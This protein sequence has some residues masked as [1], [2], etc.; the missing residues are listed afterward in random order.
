MIVDTLMTSLLMADCS[1]KATYC[2][3]WIICYPNISRLLCECR[4][5]WT[6]WQ[7]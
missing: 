4:V 1:Q 3:V 6:A 2:G 7:L 5:M